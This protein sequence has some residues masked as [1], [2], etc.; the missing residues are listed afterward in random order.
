MATGMVPEGAKALL[1]DIDGALPVW[2]CV[3]AGR[4][5]NMGLRS[6]SCAAHGS[7][8]RARPGRCA[9]ALEGGSRSPARY[10]PS[11]LRC[12]LFLPPASPPRAGTVLDSNASRVKSWQAAAGKHGLRISREEYLAYTGMKGARVFMSGVFQRLIGFWRTQRRVG[13]VHVAG[14]RA[15]LRLPRNWRLHLNPRRDPHSKRMQAVRPSARTLRG[16][17]CTTP[18]SHRPSAPPLPPPHTHAP[19]AA[20]S[21]TSWPATRWGGGYAI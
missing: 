12:A 20:T 4:V 10:P 11:A 2:T 3:A 17:P 7:P 9:V 5:G 21:W 6:R 8:N 16:R 15:R 13:A 18:S 1:F 19:Q 14:S